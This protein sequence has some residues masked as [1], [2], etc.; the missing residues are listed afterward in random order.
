[1]R[2]TNHRLAITLS[3][4]NCAFSNLS[5]Q[6]FFLDLGEVSLNRG[7]KKLTATA[8]QNMFVKLLGTC[9]EINYQSF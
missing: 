7:M 8:L 4:S 3:L 9:G 2:L 5:S 6:F 1:M